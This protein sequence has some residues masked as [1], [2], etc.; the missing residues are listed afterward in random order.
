MILRP[1]QREAIDATYAYWESE[2]GCP[3]IELATGT[4]EKHSPSPRWCAS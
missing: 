3:L 4:G 2:G 1:Y